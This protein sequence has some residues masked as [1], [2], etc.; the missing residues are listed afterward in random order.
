MSD[1]YDFLVIG[2][3][4]AGLSAAIYASRSKLDTLVLEGDSLGGQLTNY[5]DLENYP[6]LVDITATDLEENLQEHARKFGADLVKKRVENLDTG[7]FVKEVTTEDGEIYRSKSILI[8]TGAE[9]RKLGV[10][11]EEEFSGR[12]VSYCATC[13]ADFY[14]DLDVLVVGNGNSAVEEALHLTDF[15]R[16]VTLVVIHEEGKMDAEELFQEQAYEND[17]I[18]FEWNSTLARVEGDQIV[19]KAILKNV[20]T[21]EERE[22]PCDG[23][24]VFVGRVPST[25]FLENTSVELDDSGYVITDENMQTN[26]QGVYAAGDV[27]QK[28]VR[29]VITA[30]GDGATAAGESQGYL[31]AEEHWRDN[32]LDTDNQ[33]VV[34]FWSP[35]HDESLKT[36]QQLENLGV[37]EDEDKK[38]VK[39]DTYRNDLITSRYGIEDIPT[40][41][42]VEDSEETA[43]AIKPG[44]DELEALLDGQL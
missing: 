14:V 41:L 3:G 7:N 4:P 9:P 20:R 35:T 44:A 5:E 11:G 33:V 17:R 23:V 2:G 13:D 38:L 16:R 42:T 18:D 24:F 28:N 43:R 19:E 15:A 21:G 1:P 27:R 25:D 29:Q 31:E 34:V 8:A 10:P 40:I 22:F 36:L 30:A 39:I 12:G 26:V 37:E 32:V 6:G